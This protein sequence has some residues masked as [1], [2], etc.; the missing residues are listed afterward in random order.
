MQTYTALV[1]KSW[2]FWKIPELSWDQAHTYKVELPSLWEQG[3]V[4]Y[5][6][7]EHQEHLYTTNYLTSHHHAPKGLVA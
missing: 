4:Y 5:V 2:N 3:G 6:H 7:N 1:Y